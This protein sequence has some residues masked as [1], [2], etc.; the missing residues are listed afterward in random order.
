M[1]N[2]DDKN[3][4]VQALDP[5]IQGSVNSSGKTFVPVVRGA[6]QKILGIYNADINGTQGG[7]NI[8]VQCPVNTLL[9][10][11][12][13]IKYTCSL[14]L[15]G[16]CGNGQKLLVPGIYDALRPFP[17]HRITTNAVVNF[18][19]QQVMSVRMRDIHPVLEKLLKLKGSGAEDLC[20]WYP[21][22]L[23]DYRN[24]VSNADNVLGSFTNGTSE[25]V[26]RGNFPLTNVYQVPAAGGAPTYSVVE[27]TAFEP[28]LIEPFSYLGGPALPGVNTIML[29]YQFGGDMGRMWSHAVNADPTTANRV[30]T[31]NAASASFTGI[32]LHLYHIT[33]SPLDVIDKSWSTLMAMPFYQPPTAAGALTAATNPPGAPDP[34][35]PAGTIQDSLFPI[36]GTGTLTASLL[37]LSQI[38]SRLII[39]VARPQSE[40]TSS[41]PAS[42]YPIDQLSITLNGQQPLFTNYRKE[43]LYQLA[44][45][46]GYYRKWVEYSGIGI[47]GSP[48]AAGGGVVANVTAGG[49]VIVDFATDVILP[50]NVVPGQNYPCQLTVQVTAQN[51]TTAAVQAQLYMI[52][53]MPQMLTIN[54]DQGAS[55]VFISQSIVDPL[56][57]L[58]ASKKPQEAVAVANQ[59]EAVTGEAGAS[60]MSGGSFWN[61]AKSLWSSAKPLLKLAN[62]GLSAADQAGLLGSGAAHSGGVSM[63]SGADQFSGAAAMSG[64]AL[65][66]RVR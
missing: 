50:A 29:Q 33:P 3:V 55:S 34:P 11:V 45:K 1:A 19:G 52:V 7:F 63:V 61:T 47:G 22:T 65:R 56:D 57:V 49:F 40:E 46:N 58:D 54:R 4:K 38:P 25:D 14:R 37:Q 15:P 44:R 26:M 66:K 32:Q 18:N 53:E 35:Y 62:K 20:P 48:P 51:Y 43:E 12:A 31:P 16:T 21:D 27:W 39:W 23:A 42:F 6:G 64:A 36:P 41:T 2:Y 24:G 8:N 10:R 30:L 59:L 28:V 13:F 17:M 9:S 5:E 60:P